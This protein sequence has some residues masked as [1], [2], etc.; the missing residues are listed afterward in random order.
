MSN[1]WTRTDHG[2]LRV[3]AS[4]LAQQQPLRQVLLV[5]SLEDV[6]ALVCV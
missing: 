3:H 1:E 4:G 5:E 6:L 2:L